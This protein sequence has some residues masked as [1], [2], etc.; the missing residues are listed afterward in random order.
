LQGTNDVHVTL[1]SRLML[2]EHEQ[3]IAQLSMVGRS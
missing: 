3:C 2:G 1:S